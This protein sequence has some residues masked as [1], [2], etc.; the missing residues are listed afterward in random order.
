MS[1]TTDIIDAAFYLQFSVP[2]PSPTAAPQLPKWTARFPCSIHI[3]PFVR[4][5]SRLL[6]LSFIHAFLL[7]LLL[8][9]VIVSCIHSF[10]CSFVCSLS[11]AYT[12]IY[13]YIYL[14]L[15]LSLRVCRICI[16]SLY[17]HAYAYVSLCS[18]PVLMARCLLCGEQEYWRVF[19][20][21]EPQGQNVQNTPQEPSTDVVNARGRGLHDASPC[22]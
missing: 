1:G 19:G 21:V 12:Y 7:S 9:S 8:T 13:I 16:Y 22:P 5:F 2:Y 6:I 3:N 15:S 11:R 20:R 10:V 18:T 17:R 4:S 14:S